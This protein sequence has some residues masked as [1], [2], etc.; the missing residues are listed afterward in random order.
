MS[1]TRAASAVHEHGTFTQRLTRGELTRHEVVAVACAVACIHARARPVQVAGA[2]A[3]TVEHRLAEA[4]HPLLSVAEQ[5]AEIERV[6]ALERFAHAF[7]V[8]HAG[9]LD[10]RARSGHVRECDGDLRTERIVLE[11]GR[12]RILDGG[13]VAIDVADDLAGLVVDLAVKGSAPIAETLVRAYRDAGGEPGE[14]ALIAFYAAYRALVRAKTTLMRAA[15]HAPTSGAHGHESAVARELLAVAE[16]FAWR[17]RLPLAIV[18]CGAPA[19]GRSGVARALA[20]ASDL[21][22]LR[23]DA[24]RTV[25]ALGRRAARQIAAGG[26]AVVDATLA[27]RSD[28]EGFAAGFGAA[29]PVVF[30]ECRAPAASA[31][32][33]EPLDEVAADAHLVV[34]ADRPVDAVT[35]DVLGLLDERLGRL[36]A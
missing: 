2:P 21:P 12:A 1:S 9:M 18:V 23:A 14:D 30:V 25:A 28:R 32:P 16:R 24:A 33:V 17:A 15:R 27:R 20:E 5:R 22:H 10:E 13:R 8:A 31:E 35:A 11:G 29:A 19:S 34:R 26:G 3:L 6:L 36:V 4:F 7:L